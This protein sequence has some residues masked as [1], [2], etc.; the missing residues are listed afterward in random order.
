VCL[1]V[2]QDI[3]YQGSLLIWSTARKIVCQQL[4]WCMCISFF[5]FFACPYV[6]LSW[7]PPPRMGLA[8]KRQPPLYHNCFPAAQKGPHTRTHSHTSTVAP[9]LHKKALPYQKG[10]LL[11]LLLLLLH[12]W[13]LQ[14]QAS[15]CFFGYKI[16]RN[17]KTTPSNGVLSTD[18]FINFHQVRTTLTFWNPERL[19]NHASWNNVQLSTQE[20]QREKERTVVQELEVAQER[21]AVRTCLNTL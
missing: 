8:S 17:E 12:R 11:L 18:R 15:A 9:Q 20:R 13:C 19:C 3:P 6:R 16:Q 5:C 4:P 7:P 10:C 21:V 1:C 14:L 2:H